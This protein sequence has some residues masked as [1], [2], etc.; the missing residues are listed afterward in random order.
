MH[1]VVSYKPYNHTNVKPFK[2]DQ[3]MRDEYYDGIHYRNL[4]SL[5][6]LRRNEIKLF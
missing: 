1:G 2:G 3:L 4:T 6:T 5:I